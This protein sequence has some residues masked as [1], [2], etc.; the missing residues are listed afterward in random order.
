MRKYASA[1]PFCL[2]GHV[3][4]F[5]ESPQERCI[6]VRLLRIEATDTL[7]VAS[8]LGSVPDGHQARY[9]EREEVDAAG[10]KGVIHEVRRAERISFL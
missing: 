10:K 6:E 3:G 5:L 2:V 7:G 8:S 9:A 1:V 4:R